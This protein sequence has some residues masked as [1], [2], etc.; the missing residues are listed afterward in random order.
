MQVDEWGVLI[1]F[2]P[3]PADFWSATLMHRVLI[4]P[5]LERWR[6]RG[7]EEGR[8]EVQGGM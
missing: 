3:P 2:H 4:C 1:G 6:G 5:G 8:G 7:A